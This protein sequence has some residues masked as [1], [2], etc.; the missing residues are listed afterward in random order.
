MKH[1]ITKKCIYILIY[2]FRSSDPRTHTNTHKRRFLI[3]VKKKNKGI[4]TELLETPTHRPLHKC[5]PMCAYINT[6]KCKYI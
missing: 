2:I 6:Y 1:I 3:F 4:L 5:I